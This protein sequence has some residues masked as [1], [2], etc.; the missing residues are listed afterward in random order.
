MELQEPVLDDAG[1]R[2]ARSTMTYF[3][4]ARLASAFCNISCYRLWNRYR[5]R[6]RQGQGRGQRLGR[7]FFP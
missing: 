1:R 4:V 2:C 7:S 6:L 5:E 3:D